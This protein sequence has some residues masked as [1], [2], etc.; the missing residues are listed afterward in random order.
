MKNR[1]RKYFI[2]RAFQSRY[3]AYTVLTLLI[4]SGAVMAG[5]HFGIWASVLRAF[6]ESSVRNNVITAA[7]LAEY[8]EARRATGRGSALPSMRSFRE[9]ELLSARDREMIH[10]IMVETNKKTILL[11]LI[12]MFAIGWGSIYLTHKV[13]GPIFKLKQHFRTLKDGDLTARIQFRKLDEV[14]DIAPHFNAMVSSLDAS[15]GNLKH[16]VRATHGNEL[17]GKLQKELQRFKTTTD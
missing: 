1:R 3:I 4:V 2:Q 15:I 13:A 5:S 9:T 11:G 17:A 8:E 12:L 7:Q 16:I 14:Q 6:S 10:E